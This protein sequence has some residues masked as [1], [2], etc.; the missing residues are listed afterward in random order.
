MKNWP[1]E[2]NTRVAQFAGQFYPGN[3]TVLTNQL[4]E[5]FEQA[6][7]LTKKTDQNQNLQA[8]IVPHA[9]YVFSG[10]CAAY[11]YNAIGDGFDT[12]I[13]LGFSHRGYGRLGLG[14]S[15]IDWATPMGICRTDRETAHMLIKAGAAERDNLLLAYHRGVSLMASHARDCR[16]VLCTLA[17]NRCL[18]I[19]VTLDTISV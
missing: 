2:N 12:Y 13:I 15:L 14:V 1:T 4:T 16:F 6:K 19:R 17:V 10:E 8:L 9:G 5:F 7:T 18:D 11:G 3:K